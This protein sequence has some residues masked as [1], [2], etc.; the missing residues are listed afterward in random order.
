MYYSRFSSLYF[1]LAL[2]QVEMEALE[3]QTNKLDF[4][5]SGM[6]L[7]G[8]FRYKNEWVPHKGS[9]LECFISKSDS[10]DAKVHNGNV[11]CGNIPTD[12]QKL[13][14]KFLK[15]DGKITAVVVGSSRKHRTKGEEIPVDYIFTGEMTC[16]LRNHR[17][18]IISG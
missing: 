11:I 4:Y 16:M 5:V 10:V 7:R 13:W 6:S 17:R 3:K 14:R 9:H 15:G 1:N 8:F 2:T 12:V 18:S